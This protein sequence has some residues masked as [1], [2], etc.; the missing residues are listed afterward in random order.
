MKIGK[1]MARDTVLLTLMQ[2]GLDSAALLLSSF[3]TRRLGSS[4]TGILS[5]IGS[6]LG[7]A[8]IL[9]G[10]N[11]FLC[12]S[13]LISEE[14]GRKNGHPE[15]VLRHGIGL[16]LC[17]S[18]AVSAALMCLAPLISRSFFSGAGM[19]FAVRLMPAALV[20]GAVS[21]CL[22]GYFNAVRRAGIAAIGD[23]AEF[24]L[25]AS[26]IVSL[27]L[28]Q[29][30]HTESSVCRI[31][32]LSVIVGNAG[33]LLFLGT[34]Y[35][36]RK[37][38]PHGQSR[39]SF[40]GYAK[41]AF[42][43]MGGG[44]LTAVLS[45]TNDALV[46]FCL[47][48][49]GDSAEEALGLFGIFEAIVIPTIFFP[50]VVLCSVA[51]IVVSE[52]ARAAASRDSRRIFSLTD[53]LLTV[54]LGYAIMA[55]AVLMRFGGLIGRLLG[56]GETAGKMITL[57]APVV[58]FIYMEILLEAQIKGMGEQAFSSLN[59]LAEYVIRIS[60][61]LILV[62]KIG[63]WG[64]AASYYTSNVF[65][66]LNRLRKVLRLSGARL[67]I[68]RRV[69]LP[70]LYAFLTMG[71]LELVFGILGADTRSLPGAVIF[72]ALWV[73]AYALAFCCLDKTI[74]D[75]RTISGYVVQDE[76]ITI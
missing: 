18:T 31:L 9:A 2:L 49:Y 12:T 65:G 56:G 40:W 30:S 59:Y 11:A 47:R 10:G 67:H 41:L 23:V 28:R 73:G 76:Q 1:K 69:V 44:V 58:P 17:L 50:S 36:L 39:L 22:K 4:A 63:F 20:T 57:I 62:P 60:A 16:C 21:A 14:L 25:R 37:K 15:R 8:G 54:T 74:A 33:S 61:V 27:T 68:L 64:I 70:A 45:S 29:S 52:F 6:F 26:V 35:L 51:G 13:R 53:R 38:T 75:R 3:I 55:A 48:Q 24:L 71:S 42:P 46:P 43:I 19:T 34:A 7:L 66:N 72:A 5:L 32:I